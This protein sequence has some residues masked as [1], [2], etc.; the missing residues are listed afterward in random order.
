MNRREV[1]ALCGSVTALGAG[2]LGG[3]DDVGTGQTAA[4]ETGQSGSCPR[5]PDVEGLPERPDEF[6]AEAVTEFLADY[7]YELFLARNPEY[8]QLNYVE[9]VRTEQVDGGYRVYFFAEPLDTAVD[10]GHP[11]PRKDGHVHSRVL[12]RRG[13]N[14]PD[15][16]ARPHREHGV[17]TQRGRHAHRVLV[18]LT[19]APVTERTSADGTDGRNRKDILPRLKSS[20]SLLEP[21]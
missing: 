10:T 19:S 6:T 18:P 1:L 5:S 16:D 12:R 15:G 7:E 14:L 9:H 20:G 11:A 21:L 2:C 13:V 4:D 3:A 17:A 8:T